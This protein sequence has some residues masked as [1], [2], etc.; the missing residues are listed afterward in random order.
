MGNYQNTGGSGGDADSIPSKH[1]EVNSRGSSLAVP[2]A[3]R[4]IGFQQGQGGMRTT[5][6]RSQLESDLE[7]TVP[8]G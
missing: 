6:S 7:D 5:D 2:Q 8:T 3:T 4:D 1:Q